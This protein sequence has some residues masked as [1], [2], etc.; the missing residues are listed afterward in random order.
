[1]PHQPIASVDPK[2]PS[3]T[4][5][6]ARLGLA[7]SPD[8][9]GRTRLSERRHQGPLQVQ[10]PFYPETDGTCHLTILHPPGGV[11]GGDVLDIQVK[12]HSQTQV[13]LTTPAAGKFYRS[14]GL[15]ARQQQ[16]LRVESGASLEWLPQE[17]IVFQGAL[18]DALTR[19]ELS[20]AA[21]FIGWEMLCLGRPAAAEDFQQGSCR[22]VLQVWRDGVPLYLEHGRYQ[23]G[24]PLLHA[25][26]GL[27]GR[28]INAT[29]VCT[30]HY[31]GLMDTLRSSLTEVAEEDYFSASQ[32]DQILVCRYLGHSAE[33]AGQL[34][35]QA[36]ALLRPALLGKPAC[37]PRIWN[38]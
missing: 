30:G 14:G 10:R 21:K 27:N 13:L 1:M 25:P 34:L 12:L 9:M 15:I 20:G 5:W 7:F 35:R 16:T 22:Q 31:P 33:R 29:L 28:P 19:V 26:W 11:V 8:E 23:G 2:Q 38:S 36:W 4:G 3:K 17:N 24:S 18:L 32:L 37:P 6:Q